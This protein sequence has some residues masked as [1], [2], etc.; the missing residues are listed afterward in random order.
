[1]V[2]PGKAPVL[3]EGIVA[4]SKYETMVKSTTLNDRK[5]AISGFNA[6]INFTYFMGKNELKYGVE[7]EGYRTEYLFK[8][9]VNAE[10]NQTENTTQLGLYAKYKFIVNKFIIEP[11]FRLEWYASL[12]EA[13]PEPRLAIK[14][15]A[16]DWFRLKFAGGVYSQNFIAASSDRDVVNLFYGFLSGPENL[17]DQFDGK[18][19][20]SRIQKADHLIFGA[21]FDL[22]KS[23][24][25]NVEG[26]YKY[27]PQ[28]TNINRN[29]LYN[30][31]EAPQGASE[32]EYKDFILEKG[33]AYGMDM[34]LK[35]DYKKV[36]VWLVYSLGF[37]TR[38]F[39]DKYGEMVSYPP[40]FDRRHNVN[41]VFS[42]ITGPKLEWEFGAR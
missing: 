13:S 19:R 18:K 25:L 40:H 21:E 17:P 22:S 36:Y 28:L 39:E 35:Y 8:N 31:S 29:K 26:Y 3:I 16:N 4:Y 5:S 23:I 42:Y 14:Y 7:L 27:F 30:E 6:A 1:V 9:F 15:N 37:V 10:I 32:V 2:I 24:S 20:T 12:A 34:V 41:F 11:G 33:N 38:Q